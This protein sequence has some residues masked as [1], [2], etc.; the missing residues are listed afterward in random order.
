VHP[1]TQEKNLKGG[2]EVILFK[3]SVSFNVVDRKD[4]DFGR[5]KMT[6]LINQ[7]HKIT[8]QEVES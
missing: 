8:L 1:P 5:Q 4:K 6:Y 2:E 3:G 7:D